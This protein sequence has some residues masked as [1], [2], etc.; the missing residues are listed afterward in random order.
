[1][2]QLLR[3]GNYKLGRNIATFSIPAISTCPGRT[4]ACAKVCY[5]LNW[6]M[7][8]PAHQ[9]VQQAN[10]AASLKRDFVDRI[11][12]QLSKSR[13][14]RAVRIHPSGD[15]FSAGY[16][17]KWTEIACRC[18]TRRFYAYT[19]SW[20][21]PDIAEALEDLAA[22]PNFHLWLSADSESGVPEYVPPGAR[23]CYMAAYDWD[24]PPAGVSLVFRVRRKSVMKRVRSA[25]VCA[26]ENGVTE[27]TNCEK[28][29]LCFDRSKAGV[30]TLSELPGRLPLEMV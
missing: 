14:F 29:A 7:G 26:K 8:S 9:L 3:R 15:F 28:C 27:N 10:H 13:T 6:R 22:L 20:R 12:K 18:P 17:R 2:K 1:M 16:V 21:V 11:C 25:L 19:R 4:E 30:L 23:V 5:A 24:L